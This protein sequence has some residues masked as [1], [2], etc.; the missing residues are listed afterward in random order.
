MTSGPLIKC[1]LVCLKNTA[2]RHPAS[3]PL[4]PSIRVQVFLPRFLL[5]LLL[6]GGLA[7]PAR[8]LA[9]TDNLL[10]AS[11]LD[12]SAKRLPPGWELWSPRPALAVRGELG[13]RD[14]RA[15][16]ALRSDRFEAVGKWT[17]LVRGIEAGKYYRFSVRHQAEQVASEATSVVVILSWCRSPD[18]TGNLQRDY[19]LPV[20]GTDA[21]RLDERT[22]QAPPAAKSVR[23]E[24]GLRWTRSG[25]VY[26]QDPQ[27]TL[28]SPPAPRR[29]RVAATRI[30][31]DIPT[32]TVAG[33]TGLM[34]KMF[35][36]VGPRKPDVVLFSENLATRFV[37]GP[38]AER[39]Q[40]IPGPLTDA[41]AAKAKQYGTY[42]IATL[43]EANGDLFH[44]TAV[45][46]DRQGRLV[47]RYR[48][49]HLT[50]EETERGL[51]PGSEFAVFDTDFGRIGLLTCWDNWFDETARALRLA[52]AEVLFLPLAGDGTREH[53]EHVWKARAMDNGVWLVA[54]STVT[55]SP[56]RILNPQGEVV[57]DATG[58]FTHAFAELDLNQQWRERYLSVGDGD[59]EAA[60]LLIKERRPDA[61]GPLLESPVSAAPTRPEK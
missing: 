1:E 3:P 47:G 48:K 42:V 61:Y 9:A 13:E 54:S 20:G 33:N 24:L 56:S 21:W 25:A 2:S 27:L 41:L 35:D 53:W 45:L 28:V 43:L 44:N 32:A 19:V 22:L 36:E 55:D 39:A 38:L 40:P 58:A 8:A 18:G 37:R 14:G 34:L 6:A 46:I 17:T 16:L 11:A 30:L 5:F 4:Q 29:V 51:T 60:T 26:W 31:P 15:V 49:I 57:A 59:G 10:G 23:V 52:G 12:P 50:M 7:G